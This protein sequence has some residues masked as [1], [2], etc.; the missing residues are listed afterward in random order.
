MGAALFFAVLEG[1]VGLAHLRD[2]KW[3]SGY[4]AWARLP[5]LALAAI[6]GALG[7]GALLILPASGAPLFGGALALLAA[8]PTFVFGR[9]GFAPTRELLQL[10]PE[11]VRT[12]GLIRPTL[13]AWTDIEDIQARG[14]GA[15]FWDAR[16]ARW[17][18]VNDPERDPAALAQA[19]MA[20][21]AEALR[22]RS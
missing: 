13:I 12:Y 7:V 15:A 5:V 8:L 17:V 14:L 10:R 4:S 19:L 3:R 20:H 11:G 2:P 16:R 1:L 9:W 22:T 21:R 18:H 6:F